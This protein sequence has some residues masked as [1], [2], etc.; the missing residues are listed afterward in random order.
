MVMD[1]PPRTSAKTE[2]VFREVRVK[3]AKSVNVVLMSWLTLHAM[4]IHFLGNIEIYSVC[5]ACYFGMTIR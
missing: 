2:T 1:K 4:L 5:K 3:S